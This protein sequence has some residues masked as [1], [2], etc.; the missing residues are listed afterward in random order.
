MLRRRLH[1]VLS[2]DESVANFHLKRRGSITKRLST[3]TR[4]PP[5]LA[6]RQYLS[7]TRIL[8]RT[9]FPLTFKKLPEPHWNV[10]REEIPSGNKK[11]EK[12][13]SDILQVEYEDITE[14]T[15]SSFLR[16]E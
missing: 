14:A 5:N 11:L 15:Q 2:W 6:S 1:L 4:L 16:P 13:F 7:K 12:D 9:S 10:D 3:S 8:R